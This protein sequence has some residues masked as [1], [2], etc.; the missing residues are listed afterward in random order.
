[1]PP[2]ID[3]NL[4]LQSGWSKQPGGPNTG[5]GPQAPA[6]FDYSVDK[7][8][9]SHF[10]SG[11]AVTPGNACW[12]SSL[13]RPV[14]P[15][16]GRLRLA[17][18]E[19]VDASTL[20][21]AQARENDINLTPEANGPTFMAGSQVIYAPGPDQGHLQLWKNNAWVDTGIVL[22]LPAA[23]G[24][25]H[26]AL[27]ISFEG[28]AFSFVSYTRNGEEYALGAEFQNCPGQML[29]WGACAQVYIQ[30]DLRPSGGMMS[31]RSRN[32]QF[33]WE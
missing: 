32:I 29:K 25:N 15:N 21:Y 3:G 7:E 33:E 26:L 1:M 10:C 8:S 28:D 31:Q 20:L 27:D 24:W 16:T 19:L 23:W 11:P 17:W 9:I 2:I 30:Q 4:E 6:Y 5:I 13:K 14:Q 22:G 18:D 12:L